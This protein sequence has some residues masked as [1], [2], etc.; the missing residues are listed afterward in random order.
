VERDWTLICSLLLLAGAAAGCGRQ[1]VG[2]ARPET[3]LAWEP[4]S[5]DPEA[6]ITAVKASAEHTYVG[7]SDGEMFLKLNVTGGSWIPYK[8][9]QPGCNP[10]MLREAVTSFAVTEATTFVG[11]AG[12]PG[13]IK[14][15]RSPDDRPCWGI[16]TISDD[17]ISLSV[18][19]FSTIDLLAVS[20]DFLWVS[21]SL[22]G[23]WNDAGAL[24]LNFPRTVQALA[25]G[26]GAEG[27]ARAW[28]GDAAGGVY[29][30]D[31][32]GSATEPSAI[33]W[34]ALPS[35]GFPKRPVVAIATRIERPQTIWI[36]FAGLRA[37]SLWTSDD[38]GV[39][40]RNPHGGQLP[41]G[42]GTT[43]DG[44]ASGDPDAGVV[45]FGFTA[46]SPVPGLG[47]AYVTALIPDHSRVPVA[48]SFWTLDGSDD[49]W[50]L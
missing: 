6:R 32:V 25:T 44:G 38:N 2:V 13:P 17:I 35:P 10:P 49:W 27:G 20:P 28:L 16:G 19:P 50:R 34:H 24:A 5:A 15:W 12:E 8:T 31:D 45:G 39:T 30:S 14:I 46:V 42:E 47:A 36:T 40:W 33:V 4:Q 3:L 48:T 43:V 37:D 22:G 21:Q 29:Y 23:S 26:A 9:D 41:V 11:Y 18:S 1:V 7:F